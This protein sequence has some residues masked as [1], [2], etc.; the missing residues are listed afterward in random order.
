MPSTTE[1]TVQQLSRLV[2][3][4]DAPVLIDVRIDEDYQADPRLL[5]AS[6]R[7][8][9]RTVANWAGEFTG[10]RVV[11]ICQ[12]GQKLSQGV[13][14]WLRHEGIE[15]ES[16]EG[17]FEAWAAA[18]APLVTAGAIPPRD[19]KGRTVWVTRARP[20]VDR[21]A[22][23]WLI[24]RFVDPEAVFLFVDAAEVPAVADRFSAVPFDI[25]NVFWSHRGER[26]TFDTMIEEFGLASE[27]LDRLALI[28]RAADTARLDLVPQAAGFLA[29]SLG[30]SRM[31]RDDLEQLEAGMLLYDAFFRWCRDATE[32]T[33]NWPSGSKP[34]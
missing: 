32:E 23:P 3:L 25:D 5:P 8:N 30:L 7:R 26:C 11:I 13:A 18:K 20:K 28:V 2:G 6:C 19:D 15:A 10:S 1:I 4:P 24:R 9:F 29:A 31:F 16:L 17:G 27:A 14:A 12:K 21:I 22:C 33:H 34:S